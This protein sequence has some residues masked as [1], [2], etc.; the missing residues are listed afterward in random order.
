MKKVLSIIIPVY[1]VE[2]YIEEC[3]RSITCQITEDVE[4]IVVNDGTSDRSIEI[5]KNV[6]SELP[7]DLQSCFFFFFK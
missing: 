3:M 2:R 1:G 5:A 6:V 7:K 4:V